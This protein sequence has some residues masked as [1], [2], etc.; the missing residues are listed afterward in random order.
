MNSMYRVQ[1][2]TL[3]ACIALPTFAAPCRLRG[4]KAPHAEEEGSAEEGE[5]EEGEGKHEGRPPRPLRVYE[6]GKDAKTR[7]REWAEENDKELVGR[8]R[9]QTVTALSKPHL[10]PQAR[11]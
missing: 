10:P 9:L 11:L 7:L 6:G 2:L 5:E 1:L 8:V 3:L 4:E